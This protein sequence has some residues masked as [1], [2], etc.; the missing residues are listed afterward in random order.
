MK[1]IKSCLAQT[2]ILKIRGH[3]PAL[4]KP[5]EVPKNFPRDASM[6]LSDKKLIGKARAKFITTIAQSIYRYKNYPTEEEYIA[7]TQELIKKWPFLDEGKGI[8]RLY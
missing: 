8:V 6:G 3:E 4:P 7:V 1:T 2:S 5:F